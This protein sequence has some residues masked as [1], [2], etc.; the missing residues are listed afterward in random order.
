MRYIAVFLFALLTVSVLTACAEGKDANTMKTEPQQQQMATNN[1]SYTGTIVYKELEGGFF[2]LITNDNQRFTLR[3][4]P[5][6]FRLDGL[7]VEIQGSVNKDI[8][9]FTQFGEP[10]D[11]NAVTVL[12]DSHARPPA[13]GPKK[14]K[15]L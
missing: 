13:A 14:L 7:I 1:N 15:S 5:A 8:V 6:E 2:A 9:T 11:V 12:D 3:H 4:L 10:L